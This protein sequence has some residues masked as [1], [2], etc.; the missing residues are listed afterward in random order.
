M[1]AVDYYLHLVSPLHRYSL[2][3]LAAL[4]SED[5][6]LEIVRLQ[7]GNVYERHAASIETEHEYISGEG[8]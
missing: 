8:S 2:A 4:I 1:I 3:G 5:S 6:V 7:F